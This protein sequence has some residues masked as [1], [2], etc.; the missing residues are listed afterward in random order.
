MCR[1]EQEENTS[2]ARREPHQIVWELQAALRP[3]L[4]ELGV[5]RRRMG[6][7]WWID[8]NLEKVCGKG[9]KVV[10][11]RRKVDDIRRRMLAV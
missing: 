10:Q 4:L 6:D 1:A 3:V 9:G 5:P 11:A 7:W 8:R 2:A